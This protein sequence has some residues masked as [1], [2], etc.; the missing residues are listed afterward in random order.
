VAHLLQKLAA[1]LDE[2]ELSP[3]TGISASDEYQYE[4]AI[5]T[6]LQYGKTLDVISQINTHG[7]HGMQCQLHPALWFCWQGSARGHDFHTQHLHA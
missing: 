2:K 6:F 5:D 7:Y 4:W 3:E 1:S